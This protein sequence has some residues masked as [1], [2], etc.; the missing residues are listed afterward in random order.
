MTFDKLDVREFT[1]IDSWNYK[2]VLYHI[3]LLKIMRA[4]I[5]TNNLTLANKI[6]RAIYIVD[7]NEKTKTDFN[8]KLCKGDIR[9]FVLCGKEYISQLQL[10]RTFDK[11]LEVY[12]GNTKN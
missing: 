7:F 1:L 12:Y 4:L 3:E 6:K 11:E 2:V 8:K 9:R 10:E 5:N